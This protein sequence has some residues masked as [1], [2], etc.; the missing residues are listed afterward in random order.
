MAVVEL[1]MR[2]QRGQTIGRD[3]FEH[4]APGYQK[5]GQIRGIESE[6]MR[7]AARDAGASCEIR[8]I[9]VEDAAT[10]AVYRRNYTD[11]PGTATFVAGEHVRTSGHRS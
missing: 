5:P 2:K 7:L 8:P 4:L 11:R 1:V 3:P 6:F 10:L 9:S